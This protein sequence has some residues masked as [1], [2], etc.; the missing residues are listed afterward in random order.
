MRRLKTGNVLGQRYPKS[1]HHRLACFLECRI[2]G[3]MPALLL[4]GHQLELPLSGNQ[5][6][7]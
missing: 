7:W 4:V 2:V 1:T 6:Q 5:R 3:H